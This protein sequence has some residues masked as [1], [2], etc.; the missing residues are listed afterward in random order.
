MKEVLVQPEVASFP[1]LPSYSDQFRL[2]LAD[3]VCKT[4]FGRRPSG[5]QTPSARCPSGRRR[6]CQMP[7]SRGHLADGRLLGDVCQTPRLLGDV[8]QTPRLAEGRLADA[9]WQMAV[10]QMQC[11]PDAVWQRAV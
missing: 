3:S 8:C 4:V 7:S 6:V 11:L 10:C 2:R 1:G 5:C 9:V